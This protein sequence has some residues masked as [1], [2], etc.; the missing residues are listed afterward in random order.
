MFDQKILCIG[1]NSENTDRRTHLLASENKTKNHGLVVNADFVPTAAGYYHTTI[2]DI[3]FGGIVELA[4]QFDCIIMHDQPVEDWDHWKPLLNTY[5]IM[6]KLD[7]AG[8][9]TI[10]KDTLNKHIDKL[11]RYGIG[12]QFTEQEE[13]FDQYK[14]WLRCEVRRQQV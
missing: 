14:F 3:S 1:N 5:Q 10:Y 7:C 9:N 11:I 6:L 4:K 12:P 8:Y 2:L 13:Y